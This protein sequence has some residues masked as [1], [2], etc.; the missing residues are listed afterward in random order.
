MQLERAVERKVPLQIR[1]R[2]IDRRQGSYN[3]IPYCYIPSP[4]SRFLRRDI[5]GRFV[6]TSPIYI[7]G[8]LTRRDGDLLRDRYGGTLGKSFITN[9]GT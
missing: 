6:R 3:T 7:T 5:F 4:K 1:G 2:D 9:E 8:S